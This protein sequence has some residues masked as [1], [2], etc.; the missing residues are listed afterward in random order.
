M[1]K[2]T[3][4]LERDWRV[5][6]SD[7]HNWITNCHTCPQRRNRE[8]TSSVQSICDNS[9]WIRLHSS[10]TTSTS[11]VRIRVRFLRAEGWFEKS[12]ISMNR[13]WNNSTGTPSSRKSCSYLVA[14]SLR[15]AS[16]YLMVSLAPQRTVI[17]SQKTA[18][19]PSNWISWWI[20]WRLFRVPN[21]ED[22]ILK[23]WGMRVS[24]VHWNNESNEG[25]RR[26]HWIRIWR[27]DENIAGRLEYETRRRQQLTKR[28]FSVVENSSNHIW[29]ISISEVTRSLLTISK[30]NITI[31]SSVMRVCYR[32]INSRSPYR[33]SFR[34]RENNR[35]NRIS[36][37]HE[38]FLQKIEECNI[39]ISISFE[40]VWI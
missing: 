20:T 25:E 10:F 3:K 27:T 21:G 23:T 11:F 22:G 26:I 39:T 32:L 37:Y 17:N 34:D 29:R 12:V 33:E 38:Q 36:W 19:H 5:S 1:I 31:S 28:T 13:V 8:Y 7:L 9:E 35:S 2:D 4:I 16:K 15:D 14:Y 40:I 18:R 6:W 30:R 24:Q